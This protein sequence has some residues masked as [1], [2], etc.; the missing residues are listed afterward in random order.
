[1]AKVKLTKNELKRQK[2]DLARFT[3]YLPTLELKKKQLLLEINKI[4]N[5]IERVVSEIESNDKKVA[6]WVDVF[7]EE[8]DLEPLI[9][10]E[11]IK[12]S[13]GNIAGIEIP[14]FEE[15]IF[16]PVEVDLLHTPLWV[17]NAVEVLKE[18]INRRAFLLIAEKQQQIIRNELRITIQR[19]KLFEEVKIPEARESIRVIQIFLADQQTAEVVRGKIAKS[20]IEKKKMEA[21]LS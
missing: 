12:I 19:I 6:A 18:Q 13:N 15:V 4:Q 1:M 14:I 7:A 2:D 11:D 10:I 16:S 3:R 20:K 9:G 21:A 8:V 5:H 17:D